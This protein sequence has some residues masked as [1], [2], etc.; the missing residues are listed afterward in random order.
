[1]AFQH[2]NGAFQK[3]GIGKIIF[4]VAF[5][6]FEKPRCDAQMPLKCQIKFSVLKFLVSLILHKF[7]I[8]FFKIIC[9]MYL[10][11]RRIKYKLII[12]LVFRSILLVFYHYLIL[13]SG[14]SFQNS[15]ANYCVNSIFHRCFIFLVVSE[16]HFIF[17]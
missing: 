1:M 7:G 8:W 4:L 12:F 9:H 10:F 5:S 3:G 17:K 6:S 14:F 15:I 2:H 11:L 13:A 16:T